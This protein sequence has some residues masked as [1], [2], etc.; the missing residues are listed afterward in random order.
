[1][2]IPVTGLTVVV[3]WPSGR[4]GICAANC[5]QARLKTRIQ[6]AFIDEFLLTTNIYGSRKTK[7][8]RSLVAL[9]VLWRVDQSLAIR[10]EQAFFQPVAI[11]KP[12]YSRTAII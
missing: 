3:I 9:A 2:L 6:S 4:G 8:I 1:M 10:L 11:V 5:E 7:E 12:A